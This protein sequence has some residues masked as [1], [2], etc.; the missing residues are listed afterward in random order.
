M[1][2]R[3]IGELVDDGWV[4]ENHDGCDEGH[5]EVGVAIAGSWP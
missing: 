5:V 4:C 1:A 3:G 2:V